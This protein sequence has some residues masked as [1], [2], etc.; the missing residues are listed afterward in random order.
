[1]GGQHGSESREELGAHGVQGPRPGCGA[2]TCQHPHGTVDG[3]HISAHQHLH[4]QV[5]E[6]RPGLGPV[7]VC[8]G[9]HRVGHA[10]AH[11][12]YGLP[13]AVG[14]Q[15]PDDYLCLERR[16]ARLRLTGVR[17]QQV[18]AQFMCWKSSVGGTLHTCAEPHTHCTPSHP[19]LHTHTVHDRNHQAH[20]AI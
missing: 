12:A 18:A 16:E 4:E 10:G 2:R 9:R 19:R 11:L 20:A 14:Q 7:P 17:E 8:D 15:F 1:M 6:L 3:V 5:E 13:Q